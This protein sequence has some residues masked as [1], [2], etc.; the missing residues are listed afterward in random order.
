MTLPPELLEAIVARPDDRSAYLVAADWLTSQGEPW[1]ELISAQARLQGETDPATFLAVR[2]RADELLRAHAQRWLGADVDAEWRWGFVERLSLPELGALPRLLAS[3][4][5][6]LARELALEGPP[7]QL[8]AALASLAKPGAMPRLEALTLRGAGRVDVALPPVR[9]LDVTGL[10]LDWAR[11]P[12]ALEA[13]SLR[14]LRDGALGPWLERH[15]PPTLARLELLELDLP[16]PALRE[17][18]ER[19]RALQTLHVEDDLPDELA[20]WLAR[21]P[22]LARLEHLALGGPATDE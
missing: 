15:A 6:R 7:L 3:E 20:R 5:G 16:H 9:R 8:A 18:I 21:S 11:L 4:V 1:G 12:S 22:A 14:D 13:L 10:T 19:Q 2:R 17:V